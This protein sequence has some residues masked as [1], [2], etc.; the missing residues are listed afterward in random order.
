[1][2]SSQQLID[3]LNFKLNSGFLIPGTNKKLDDF[4]DSNNLEKPTSD[5]FEDASLING[6][7]YTNTYQI[8][9]YALDDEI[10]KPAKHAQNERRHSV[11]SIKLEKKDSN[12]IKADVEIKKILTKRNN[13]IQNS[14]KINTEN[15]EMVAIKKIPILTASNIGNI[16][17]GRPSRKT[18]LN[19]RKTLSPRQSLVDGNYSAS[20]IDLLVAGPKRL[21]N[22]NLDTSNA[23]S[24]RTPHRTSLASHFGAYTP[25][26]L[27]KSQ[28][29]VSNSLFQSDQNVYIKE[30]LAEN[31]APITI[32]VTKIDHELTGNSIKVRRFFDRQT[33]RIKQMPIYNSKTDTRIDDHNEYARLSL[34]KI[35]RI[36]N[37]HRSDSKIS[38]K[39][40][41]T[42]DP[43]FGTPDYNIDFSNKDSEKNSIYTEVEVVEDDNHIEN[44][45]VDQNRE[46]QESLVE[47][48]KQIEQ[49]EKDFT[50]DLNQVVTF[51]NKSLNQVDKDDEDLTEITQ[52]ESDEEIYAD[53]NVN[54]IEQSDEFKRDK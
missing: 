47:S 29:S 12:N 19:S 27:D 46:S 14:N 2:L 18:S 49:N 37:Q 7:N 39:S 36:Q 4:D 21:E 32:S 16:K 9:E 17:S 31:L 34:G 52:E 28:L 42:V 41:M 44:V 53:L 26:A 3:N 1:M 8:D 15:M 24:S 54:K 40:K 5:E 22:D 35:A 20:K 45:F 25:N 50:K 38:N 11:V 33:M 48:N 51:D 23:F 10:S 30:T 43:P 13:S 6:V